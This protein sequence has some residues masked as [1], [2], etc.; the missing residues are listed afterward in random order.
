MHV[1]LYSGLPEFVLPVSNLQA[2]AH[3]LCVEG[4]HR[5][6]KA[7]CRGHPASRL[8]GGMGTVCPVQDLK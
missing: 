8:A 5:D 1:L 3:M 4:G 6:K 7:G 2:V